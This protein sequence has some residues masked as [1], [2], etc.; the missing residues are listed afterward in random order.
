M[1]YLN[2]NATQFLFEGTIP[3][4]C[5]KSTSSEPGFPSISHPLPGVLSEGIPAAAPAPLPPASGP[6]SSRP[7][8][9]RQELPAGVAPRCGQARRPALQAPFPLRGPDA[10]WHSAMSH[11]QQ[12][13][14]CST[15]MILPSFV[16]LVPTLPSPG[17]HSQQ[18]RHPPLSV[19]CS[20]LSFLWEASRIISFIRTNFGKSKQR[21]NF[22]IFPHSTSF[23]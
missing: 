6:C 7:H 5:W 20:S 8:P 9:R 12:R 3:S 18:V 11:P 10:P 19:L 17:S 14:I 15:H 22:P 16:F 21:R 13:T 4:G 23:P 1:E 2:K